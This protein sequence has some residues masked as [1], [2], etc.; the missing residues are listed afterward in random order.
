MVMQSLVNQTPAS[1][2]DFMYMLKETQ[3]AAGWTVIDSSDGTTFGAADNW[4]SG[5]A[6]DNTN[7]WMHLQSPDTERHLIYQRDSV[8]YNWRI[9]YLKGTYNTDGDATNIPTVNTGT[10]HWVFGGAGSYTQL[11]E[12]PVAS[13]SHIICTGDGYGGFWAGNFA[14]GTG[15]QRFGFIFDPISSPLSGDSD[16]CCILCSSY[17]PNYGPFQYNY[18]GQATYGIEGL[19]GSTW[20]RFPAVT[21]IDINNYTL[22]GHGM[23]VN[24]LNGNPDSFEA[25]YVRM[26]PLGAPQGY[27][28]LS[29]IVRLSGYN[30]L[31]QGDTLN[32]T[33]TK[34]HVVLG[35]Y[36]FISMIL[37]WDG[38]SDF[39]I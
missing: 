21:F 4:I 29:S 17:S 28:G 11:I 5:V 33:G 20:T 8:Q 39:T 32:I 9:Q 35:K 15:S 30:G 36:S 6:A 2:G 34:S 27:K 24:D 13:Y 23:G 14:I 31:N 3:V 1:G 10:G 19:L 7:A 26:T 22:F 37:P 38:V 25:A 18:F 16:I 12:N